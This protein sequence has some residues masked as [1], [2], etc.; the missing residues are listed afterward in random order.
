MLYV[1][2]LR[3]INVGGNNKVEMKTLKKVFEDLEFENVKTYINSGNVIFSSKQEKLTSISKKIETAVEKEFGFSVNVVVKDKEQIITI[4]KALP[5]TWLN[6]DKMKCDVMFL[7]DEVDKES[8]LDELP[9]KE[10][11]DDVKYVEG[12]ILWRVDRDKV[13]KSGMIKIVGTKL[14][15]QM[16]VRNCNTLRKLVA[17][18]EEIS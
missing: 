6:N 16:T 4:N 3:G 11:I 9:I 12:A 15:K 5:K 10:D 7:W 18:M 1:A 8:V 17:M 14:Y 13:T 2:L